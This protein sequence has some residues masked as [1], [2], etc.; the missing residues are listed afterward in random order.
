MGVR[1]PIHSSV[2]TTEV[3]SKP[4][5]NSELPKDRKVIYSYLSSR[6]SYQSSIF[7]P[8]IYS[9]A[10]LR[11]DIC[12]GNILCGLEA[13]CWRRRE[14]CPII[15]HVIPG[16]WRRHL[17]SRPL[18]TSY[19]IRFHRWVRSLSDPWQGSYLMLAVKGAKRGSSGQEWI[20]SSASRQENAPSPSFKAE[21][22]GYVLPTMVFTHAEHADNVKECP[23]PSAW[24]QS[25]IHEHCFLMTANTNVL[26]VYA[27]HCGLFWREY[28]FRVVAGGIAS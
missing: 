3:R 9:F 17:P 11:S 16:M 14:R 25:S 15:I 4:K 13:Q 12:Y 28:E 18:T 8:D 19:K 23:R 2:G 27:F 24:T 6:G 5:H 21:H 1:Q 20:S 26:M 7:L 22:D 10:A